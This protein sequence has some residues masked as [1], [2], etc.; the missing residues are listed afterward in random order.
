MSASLFDLLSRQTPTLQVR[1]GLIVLDLQNDFLSP[2]GKLTVRDIG[3]LEPLSHLVES[4]REWGDV[5]WVRSEFESNRPI[6]GGDDVVAGGSSGRQ[7]GME[8]SDDAE[9]SR[10]QPEVHHCAQAGEQLILMAM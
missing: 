2:E 9:S 4:F 3:F 1:K 8:S 5:I 7:A 6:D 10:N